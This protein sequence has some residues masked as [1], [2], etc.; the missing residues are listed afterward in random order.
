MLELWPI[1]AH[2]CPRRPTLRCSSEI[3]AS[4][5]PDSDHRLANTYLAPPFLSINFSDLSFS[6]THTHTVIMLST[7]RTALR[8]AANT[9]LTVKAGVRAASAWSSV[10]QGPPVSQLRNE[11]RRGIAN[12]IAGCT[13]IMSINTKQN[14]LT[15]DPRPFLASQ[16]LSRPTPTPRRSTS[17]S[18]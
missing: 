12:T 13:C 8:A 1:A 6:I 18:I 14:M 7:S 9:K 3:R 16:R 17:V 4:A 10:P 15:I 5:T 2:R 11:R